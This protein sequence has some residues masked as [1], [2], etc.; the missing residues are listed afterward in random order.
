MIKRKVVHGFYGDSELFLDDESG[1]EYQRIIGALAWPAGSKSAFA[2]VVGESK[3][4]EKK[5]GYKPGLH[6]HVLSQCEFYTPEDVLR[7]C[8]TLNRSHHV[9]AWYTDTSN[10]PMMKLFYRLRIPISLTDAPFAQDPD[11]LGLYIGIIRGRTVPGHKSLHFTGTTIPNR[12]LEIEDQKVKRSTRAEDYP[13]LA[14]L[15]YA[16]S[17]LDNSKYNPNEQREADAM[18]AAIYDYDD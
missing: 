13:V 5:N 16:L 9:Q 1:V 6:Y 8:A 17:A 4:T 11:A 3:Q 14:A 18:H 12:L 7:R 15:G 2:V 10:E